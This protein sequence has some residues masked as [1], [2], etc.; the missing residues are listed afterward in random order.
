MKSFSPEYIKHSQNIIVRKQPNKEWAKDL[1]RH[2]LHQRKYMDF[3]IQV[4]EN[5]RSLSIRKMQLKI[6]IRY[7]YTLIRMAKIKKLDQTKCWQHCKTTGIPL[8]RWCK[9]KMVQLPWRIVWKLLKNLNIHLIILSGHFTPSYLHK[10]KKNIWLH[11][12]FVY[13]CLSQLYV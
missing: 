7:P 6:T 9:C 1:N 3:L 12:D 13:E 5:L 2:W 8:H 4:H 11:K 10:R